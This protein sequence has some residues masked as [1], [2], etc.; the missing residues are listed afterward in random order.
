MDF[1]ETKYV[2]G[3]PEYLGGG[4]DPSPFTALGVYMGMK[5]AANK[6]Y[7]NDS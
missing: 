5:A 1:K 7:G 2:T 3:L 4:G 6:A